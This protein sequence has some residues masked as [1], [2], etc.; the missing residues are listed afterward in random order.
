MTDNDVLVTGITTLC[1]LNMTLKTNFF[2][3]AYPSMGL[4]V[5]LFINTLYDMF[6]FLC[7]FMF[8]VI[9]LA[10]VYYELKT[11]IDDEDFPGLNK[12]VLFCLFTFENSLGWIH[13]PTLTF[14]DKQNQ[15]TLIETLIWVVW[16]FN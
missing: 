5:D 4:L 2:M 9:T 7:Y 16:F 11:E 8:L 3:K 1:I 12:G 15:N 6:Q 10:L 13:N 14:W